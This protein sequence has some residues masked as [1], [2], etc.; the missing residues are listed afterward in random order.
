MQVEVTFVWTLD[1]DWCESWCKI[2]DADGNLVAGYF[3]AC[4]N[5]GCAACDIDDLYTWFGGDVDAV[6]ENGIFVITQ[7]E[8]LPEGEYFVE[9]HDG[10][11]GW[12]DNSTEG[13]DAF[14]IS[15]NINYSID[16]TNGYLTTDISPSHV[17]QARLY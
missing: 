2:D 16:F 3:S 10:Y 17:N 15:G 11:D 1:S 7:T 6:L 4:Q 14:S 12:S 8:L 5:Q 13:I 9:M